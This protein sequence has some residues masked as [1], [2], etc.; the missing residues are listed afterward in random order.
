MK[1]TPERCIL[2]PVVGE[3]RVRRVFRTIDFLALVNC[4]V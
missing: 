2:S 4:P 3:Y 1:M